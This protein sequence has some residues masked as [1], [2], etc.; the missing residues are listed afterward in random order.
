VFPGLGEELHSEPTRYTGASAEQWVLRSPESAESQL[1]RWFGDEMM[2]AT[3]LG[4]PTLIK[5]GRTNLPFLED[6]L[7]DSPAWRVERLPMR[8]S[9]ASAHPNASDKYVRR[10]TALLDA[11]TGSLIE[12]KSEWPQGTPAIKPRASARSAE[13]QM[14]RVGPEE[15]LA[16]VSEAPKV[17]FLEALDVVRV[18]G[19]SDPLLA[20]QIIAHCV[21]RRFGKDDPRPVWAITLRGIGL[22]PLGG[23]GVPIDAR[24]HIR[25]IVDANTGE[26]LVASTTPQPEPGEGDVPVR[27]RRGTRPAP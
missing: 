21:V 24:N 10:F 8:L 5:A 17:S 6:R 4:S 27:R 2:I 11:N 7:K 18:R 15:Y 12:I 9:L 16:L 26:W 1:R 23:A 20:K 13:L 14:A 25:N 19:V 22:L 3:S